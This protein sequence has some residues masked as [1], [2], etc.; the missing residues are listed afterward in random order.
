MMISTTITKEYFEKKMKDMDREGHFWEF[1]D[2]SE[3]WKRLLKVEVP[4]E[5]VFLVGNKPHRFNCVFIARWAKCQMPE[6]YQDA[7]KTPIVWALQCVPLE[8]E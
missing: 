7:V 4:T 5:I 6:E 3:H 1:K 8:D 2:T